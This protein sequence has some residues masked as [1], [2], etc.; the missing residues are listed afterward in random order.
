MVSVGSIRGK[1]AFIMRKTALCEQSALQ[2]FILV[3]PARC[4]GNLSHLLGQS[5]GDDDMLKSGDQDIG[6]RN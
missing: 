5:P 3:S 4:V 1:V 2:L 6:S